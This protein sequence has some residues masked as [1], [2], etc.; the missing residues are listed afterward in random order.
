MAEYETREHAEPD[1]RIAKPM[2]ITNSSTSDQIVTL[3]YGPNT[4]PLAAGATRTDIDVSLYD[5]GI[6]GKAPSGTPLPVTIENTSN[7]TIYPVDAIQG[8][9]QTKLIVGT[10]YTFDVALGAITL[11]DTEPHVRRS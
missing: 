9:T 8:T 1:F 4:W 10:A 3:T 11:V 6:S 2:N 5:I 7:T